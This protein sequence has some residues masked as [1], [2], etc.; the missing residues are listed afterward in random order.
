MLLF[1]WIAC[2]FAAEGGTVKFNV[3][4]AAN[5]PYSWCCESE[6]ESME[7]LAILI[8]A[9]ASMLA[10]GIASSQLIQKAIR[11]IFGLPEQKSKSYSERLSELTKKLDGASKEVDEVLQEIAG[12]TERRQ[13]AVS[14]LEYNLV[15]L[16]KHEASLKQ[17]IE[18]LENTPVEAAQYFTKIVSAGERRGAKRDYLLF[19][20]GVLL[21]SIISIAL[22]FF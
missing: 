5:S 22:Q 2:I 9:A 3:A 10:G 13:K 21:T 17:R 11:K 14:Q 19:G 12:V 1:Q 15:E 7:I 16:E 8:A 4:T 18:A 6:G 20:A